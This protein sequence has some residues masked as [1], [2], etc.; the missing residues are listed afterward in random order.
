MALGIDD[1]TVRDKACDSCGEAFHHVTGF[2]KDSDGP[3]AVYFA[4]CHGHPD[5]EAQIDVVLGSWGYDPPIQDHLT[6][7]C[8]LRP[9]GASLADAPLASSSDSAMLGV[10]LSRQDA[11]DHPRVSDF[12]EVID[13]LAECD[14]SINLSV[15]GGPA[16]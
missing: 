15:H 13:L 9:E 11:L 12:W 4:A 16:Q 7:S 6:F 2:I 5:K 10:R 1:R 14:E 3:Y 8:R